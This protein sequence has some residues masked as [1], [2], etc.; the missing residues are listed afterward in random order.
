VRG[1]SLA[2]TLA[3]NALVLLV[4]FVSS[5][6]AHAGDGP[7]AP[8]PAAQSVDPVAA[9]KRI[10][11]GDLKRE[12]AKWGEAAKAYGAALDAD[13]GNWLAHV[14]YQQAVYAAGE[15]GFL[16]TEYDKLCA[17]SVGDAGL[18]LHRIRLDPPA[19]RVPVLQALVKGGATD[20][21]TLL[22]LGRAQLTAGDVAGAKRTL[23]GVWAKFP[24]QDEAL[25]LSA[26][27][28]RL[29]GDVPGARARLEGAL[30]VRGDLWE[31]ALR[32]ARL[33][34]LEA[35]WDAAIQ[36]ADA[37]LGLRPS[38]IAA[39]LVKSEATSRIGKLEDAR[40]ALDSALRV[41]PTDPEALVAHADFLARSGTDENLKKAVETY[42][43]VL[44]V[45]GAPVPAIR[46]Y[47]GIGWAQERLNMLPEAVSAYREAANLAPTDAGIVNSVGFVFLKQKKFQDA[48]LQF[49]KAI[50]LDPGAPEAYAN[51][52]AVADEQGDWNE[53]IK[54]YDKV[55]KLKGHDKHLRALL[56]CAFDYEALGSYKKAED[57]LK[58]AKQV[59]PEDSEITTY[60]G[61]NQFFQHDYGR[62]IKSY[63]EATRL[64]EK[65]RFAWR[66]LGL[67]L[68]EASKH[69]DAVEALEKAKALKADDQVTLIS[70]GDIYRHDLENLEK[71][72]ENYQAYLKA[73]GNNPDIPLVIEDLKK[74]IEEK[75]GK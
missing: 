34:L 27:A 45:K 52:G 20:R 37:V 7:P 67:S 41:N 73:G 10:E 48:L 62:A 47:Y 5:T 74:E 30:K 2:G 54:W 57:Y 14:R 56:C 60:L 31:V 55:L 23:D 64:D 29:S 68:Q 12:E 22:E 16:P 69:E 59:R 58:R 19:G 75:K 51:K 63:Q 4:P 3:A 38:Y 28:L 35:K 6:L 17:E 44:T 18:R 13:E 26:E 71:A 32:I 43:K 50:D 15:G 39:F 70:L 42:Q 65:N 33:D 24:D 9:R 40:S 21:N 36:R 1:T 53:A 8:A 61:D 25:I 49:T 46:V 66:G 11:E 72:L